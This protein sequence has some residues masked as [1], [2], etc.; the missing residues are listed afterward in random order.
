MS[1]QLSSQW[2][3]HRDGASLPPPCESRLFT[4][5]QPTSGWARGGT[6][7]RTGRV[8]G[9]EHRTLFPCGFIIRFSGVLSTRYLVT[10]VVSGRFSVCGQHDVTGHSC[11]AEATCTFCHHL[12]HSRSRW[13]CGPSADSETRF[14][15]PN[16]EPTLMEGKGPVR[17]SQA[18][19]SEGCAPPDLL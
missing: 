16:N 17:R 10:T 9:R 5:N 3:P 4:E 15:R 14:C 6:C 1:T 19:D 2:P 11:S 7:G 12:P 8:S 18:L 13:D